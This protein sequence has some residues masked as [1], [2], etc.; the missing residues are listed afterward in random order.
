MEDKKKKTSET[1]SS[2]EGSTNSGS[3]HEADKSHREST[4]GKPSETHKTSGGSSSQKG[5]TEPD[6]SGSD[7]HK[8]GHSHDKDSR[9]SSSSKDD[10]SMGG[11]APIKST[12]KSAG[13]STK[14]T[15]T[16]SEFDGQVSR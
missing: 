11:P 15:V 10:K 4:T 5:K 16:G 13:S 12:L 7:R 6:K 2:K 1:N 14:T 8:D 3:R 9:A